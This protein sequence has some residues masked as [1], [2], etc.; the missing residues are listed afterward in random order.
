MTH[1]YNV[2]DEV[3]VIGQKKLNA[4]DPITRCFFNELMVKCIGKTARVLSMSWNGT[5]HYWYYNLSGCGTWQWVD[6]WLEPADSK[7]DISFEES[8]LAALL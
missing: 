5:F 4:E 6:T 2:G 1:N 7:I 3:V 8:A